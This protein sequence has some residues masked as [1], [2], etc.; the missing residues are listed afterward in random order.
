M[1][2]FYLILFVALIA[3]SACKQLPKTVPIDIAAEQAAINVLFDQVDSAFETRDV[4]TLT[5][6]L[7]DDLLCCGTD[8]SEFWDKQQTTDLWTQMF[9]DTAVSITLNF[10]SD[11]KIKVANDGQ[12]AAV[13]EQYLFPAISPNIPWR[14]VYH[15]VKKDDQWKILF[16]SIAFIPKNE[17]IAKI[18]EA[19][20]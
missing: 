13:V 6:F 11:R 12:S 8:P 20:E 2:K 9:A 19:V 4:T 5:S 15:L 16:F 10:I 18:N 14:N 17:D 7:K 1:K 3:L